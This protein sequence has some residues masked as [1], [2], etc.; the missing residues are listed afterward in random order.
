[1]NSQHAYL[2]MAHSDPKHLQ[3]LIDAIDDYR[4][5]IYIHIDGKIEISKFDGITA[6]QSKLCFLKQRVNVYW[7]DPSQIDAEYALFNCVKK[8][9][10]SR[11]HLMSGADYP[12]KS[13]NEIHDFFDAH[14]SEEFINFE[15]ESRLSGELRKKMRLY[16]YFLP[17]ISHPDKYTALFFNFTRRVLLALQMVLHVNRHYTLDT[18]KK[19]SQW[20]SMSQKFVDVLLEHE[21]EIK[22][23]YKY[24]HCCDEIYKQTIAWNCGFKDNISPLGNLRMIDFSHGNG[25]SPYTFRDSDYDALISSDYLYARKFSSSI[26]RELVNRLKKY[27]NVKS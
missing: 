27:I 11:I 25:K 3:E 14:K 13:Q 23:Q 5:D 18:I 15:D 9:N 8:S 4:N 21:S 10:Y 19:G 20:A 24:T 7:G 6:K 12:L 1:M 17:Y 2:I 26:S 16:N 22:H